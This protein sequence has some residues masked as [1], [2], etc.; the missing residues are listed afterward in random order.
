M[1][2]LELLLPTRL[3][4]AIGLLFLGI[5][6]LPAPAAAQDLADTSLLV[7]SK[8]NGYRHAAIPDGIQTLRTLSNEH[9]FRVEATEDST[10]FRPER[11]STVDVVV[12]LNTSGDVLGPTGQNALRNFVRSGG[13]YVGIHAASD[14][15]Y[16]WPWY[17]RLVGTY[18]DGHPEIQEATVRIENPSQPSTHGLPTEWVR[19]D[20]WYNFRSNPRDSV[21]VLLA[22]DGSTYEGGAMGTDHPIAWRQT[23]D[24][25]RAWYTAG[26]HTKASYQD[27]LFRQHL[28]GGLRWAADESPTPK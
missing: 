10:A 13:G 21:Q 1:T 25:G 6:L 15:E 18:F 19:R 22:L 7:F 26:G 9:G 23:I 24:G 4:S 2:S 11:L 5:V 12:F 17:G 8:T 27:P 16:D 28:V 14:T 20:E 3:A